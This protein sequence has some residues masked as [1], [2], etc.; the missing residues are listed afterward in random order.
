VPRLEHFFRARN[1]DHAWIDLRCSVHG[2]GQTFENRF[3]HVV[4]IFAITNFNVDVCKQSIGKAAHEFFHQLE[5]KSDADRVDTFRGEVND[6]RSA[7]EINRDL[8]QRFVHRKQKETVAGDAH[9]ASQSLTEAGTEHDADIFHRVMEVD[10][11]VTF[12]ANFEIKKTMLG[13]KRQHVI[14][15]WHPGL[16]VGTAISIH[17][18]FHVDVG[19]GGFA[20]LLGGS[21]R[22]H[23]IKDNNRQ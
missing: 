19:F 14:K 18:Q 12:G 5:V 3:R 16:D 8:R 11:N 9:F 21:W 17:G 23:E 7:A 2:A 15:K 20:M 4:G 10:F 22:A 13:E 1:A 6:E